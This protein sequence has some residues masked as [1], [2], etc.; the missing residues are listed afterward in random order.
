MEDELIIKEISNILKRI[1]SEGKEQIVNSVRNI[2][3]ESFCNDDVL[4]MDRKLEQKSAEEFEKLNENK[5]MSIR[6]IDF[7]KSVTLMKIIAEKM[8]FRKKFKIELEYDPDLLAVMI[9]F[10]S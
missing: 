4:E 2:L 7:E 5:R 3:A 6:A 8:D 9:H 10:L 1:N